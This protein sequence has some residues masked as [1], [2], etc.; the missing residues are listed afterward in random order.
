MTPQMRKLIA[1]VRDFTGAALPPWLEADAPILTAQTANDSALYLVGMIGGKDVGKSAL[2]NALVGQQITRTTSFGPGTDQVIAYVHRS[3]AGA[4][5]ESLRTIAPGACQIVT[6]DL[7]ALQRQALLDLPDI[8]SHFSA[9]VALTRRM[10]REMLFPVFVQSVEK[11]ADHQPQ[12][13]LRQIAAGNAVENFVFCLNKADQIANPDEARQLAD[14]YAQRL[15]RVLQTPPPRV[16]LISTLR[17]DA[18]DLP[19]LRALLW[20]QKSQA[21]ILS[22]QQRAAQRQLQVARQWLVQQDLPAHVAGLTRLRQTAEEL[23]ND[24]IGLP[25]L[26]RAIPALMNDPQHKQAIVE[27]ALAARMRRWPMINVLHGFYSA[28][29]AFLRRNSE[30][31]ARPMLSEGAEVMVDAHLSSMPTPLAALVQSTFAYLQQSQPQISAL[32]REQKLWESMPADAAAMALRQSLADAVSHQ[33]QNA[34]TLLAGADGSGGAA[35]RWGLTV[36]AVV[37]FALLQPMLM[38]ILHQQTPVSLLSAL[39]AMISLDYLLHILTA[40]LIYLS[41]LWVLLRWDTRRRVERSF[42][43]WSQSSDRNAEIIGPVNRTLRWLDQLIAPIVLVQEK[44]EG[45]ATEIQSI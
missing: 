18:F 30:S 11:Y 32:Y 35:V 20:Q 10:L 1:E 26:D 33:R 4:L 23:V 16:W 43:R 6:H 45:L 14:D 39:V 3:H 40:L 13:L 27:Q 9:H 37:W 7:P 28:I 38:V 29:S 15:G 22:S 36:G 2:V 8:D 34:A 12:E 21:E 31:T 42:N 24:R 44:A 25:L 41:L 17:P 19:A 5:Q